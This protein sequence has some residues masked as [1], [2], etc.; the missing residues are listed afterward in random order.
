MGALQRQSSR[1]SVE[2][3]RSF[4]EGRPDEEH[5]ELING[6]A[7]MMAPPTLAHL[8]IAGNLQ[9]MLNEAF[10]SH[11]LAMIAIQR[12][13]V[14]VAPEVEDYDPEPDV[15]V[16]DAAIGETAGERYAPRFHLAA[17]IVSASDRVEIVGKREVYKLH[18]SC[19][20]ILTIQQDRFDVRDILR[21]RRIATAVG[22]LRFAARSL[23]RIF[24]V[25]YRR[26]LSCQLVPGRLPFTAVPRLYTSLVEIKL[27]DHSRTE[28]LSRRFL[29]STCAGR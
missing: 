18:D 12:A 29:G 23:L 1:M 25:L 16:I 5:W 3:F 8:I 28:L 17:E 20:C 11:S 27:H 10:K 4:V 14:N 13:G 19:T 24:R 21:R 15:V 22:L 26:S 6:V 2:L 9:G 7:M